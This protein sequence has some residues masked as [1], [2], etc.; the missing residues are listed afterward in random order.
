MSV[1]D[2]VCCCWSLVFLTIPITFIINFLLPEISFKTFIVISLGLV[3]VIL[4]VGGGIAVV[5]YIKSK[6]ET[7]AEE[8]SERK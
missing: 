4:A 3:G 7:S 8:T 1:T 2:A 6:R 5:D